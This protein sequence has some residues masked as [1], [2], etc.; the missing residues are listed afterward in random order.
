MGGTGIITFLHN[1]NYGS[2]LQAYA[3]QRAITRMGYSCEHIDYMPDRNEKIRN[4]LRCGNSPKLIAEGMRKRS[5]KAGQEAAR[6]KSDAIPEFYA[7]RMKLSP[8]CASHRQL[9][10]VCGKYDTLICGSDQIW[11]PV[12]LNTAYFLDFAGAGQR[13]IAYAPSLGVSEMPAARKARMIRRLTKD[14]EA[15]SVREDAGA[16]IMKKITGMQPDVMPDPVC[17]L[18]RDEWIDMAGDA[19]SDG[20]A[21]EGYLLCYF[22]GEDPK[23]WDKVRELRQKTGL[24]VRVMPVTA[25]S[26]QSGYNL[27]EGTAPEDFI[28]TLAGA[29]MLCTDS[30]HGLVFGT[31]FG[32][33]TELIRRYRDDDKESKNSRVDDFLRH[34]NEEGMDRMRERGL[35]WLKE[36]LG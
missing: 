28:R 15:V 6:R 19:A 1:D 25:E 18:T 16:A 11:N 5:V 8:R 17:L 29:E 33:K 27:T 10:E 31:V 14:F 7:R 21:E 34:V 26:F 3:L 32:R 9:A 30:F 12:W 20:A 13:K 24:Q 2:S 22:I 35:S 4:I 23:Y 36:K